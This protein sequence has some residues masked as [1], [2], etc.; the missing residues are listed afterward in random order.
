MALSTGSPLVVAL[1]FF[2]NG[3]CLALGWLTGA[4]VD[5]LSVLLQDIA[6]CEPPEVIHYRIK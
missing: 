6:L 3:G 2:L 5:N 4:D 1:D